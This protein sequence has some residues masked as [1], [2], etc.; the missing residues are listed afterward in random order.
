MLPYLIVLLPAILF[1][2]N[3]FSQ[4]QFIE[5]KGQWD[6]RVKFMSTTG[7]G[8][9][10]LQQNGFTVAQHNSNDIDNVKERRHKEAMGLTLKQGEG[11]KI[12]S[13]AY[14][15]E[16]LNSQ[17]AQIIPDKA[18]P[19]ISNYFIG[20][21]P[22][23]WVSNCKIYQGITYKN[24][25]PGID[26]RYYSDGGEN[27]KYDFIVYPGADVNK[28]V[29]KYT[30]AEKIAI[31]NKELNISTSLGDN[32]ELSPYTYQIDN[33]QRQELKCG[34]D[35]K[36]DV[37]KF[38]VKNY[39]PSKVLIID[40]TEIFFSYSGSTADNWG[41]TA[42]YGPDGSFYGGGIVF[43]DGFPKYTGGYDETFNGNFDIGI[44]KLSPD[45][46]NMIYATYIGGGDAD[47]PHSLIV[48]PQGNLVI[49]GRSSS[50][51]YP[52]W[53]A[54]VPAV[55]G[56]GGGW[57]IIVTKLN[58]TGTALI[59]SMRIGGS[60][61]DG[62]NIQDERVA[63]ANSLK[64]NYGDDARSEVLLDGANNIYLAS[65]TQSPDY[66]KTITP[67][68]FQTKIGGMQDGV[69]L[70]IDPNCDKILFNTFLGG[71]G[72]DAAY[73]LVLDPSNNIYVAGGTGS[74]NFPGISPSGVVSSNNSGGPCDGFIVELNNAGTA[75]I[76][77]TYLGTPAADQIYGIDDDK[78]GNIYVMGTTEGSWP[79]MNAAYSDA[80]AK[81]FI[82]KLKP[83]LSAYIYSTVFGSANSPLPNISPTAFLVD[84]CENVYVSGW[85]GKSNTGFN[86]GNTIGMPTTP[87]AI[88]PRTDVSGSDFYFFVLQKDA[89]SQLYGTFFGQSDPPEGVSNPLTF[90]D[91]VDGGTSRFDRNG[92]IYEAMCANCFR[93]V[94]FSGTAGAWSTRDQATAGGKCNLGM[95][96]IEMDFSGVRAG[97]RAAINGVAYDTTG[98]APVTVNFSDTLKK[99]KLYYWSFG[100][101]TGDTTVAPNDTHIYNN[102]GTYLVRL[103]AVDSTTCN[104]FDTS[105]THIK[106]GDNKVLLDFIP[107]KV[108][109][110]TNLTYSFTNT[111]VPTSGTFNP[112]IFTWDFGDN[113]PLLTASQSPPVTHTY[114]SPGTYL[115][116][117]SINDTTYCNSPADTVKT[118]RLSPQVKAQFET[119]PSGC[120]PYNAV[121]NNTSLGGTSFVWD[122]G[123]GS[124]STDVSPTHLYANAGTY[125][126]KLV[127]FDTSSCN[128]VDS[129]TFT[130]TV[131]PNPIAAFSFAPIPPQENTPTNFTN[132]SIGA[133][134]YLWRFGDGDTS[135]EVNPTHIFLATATYNV[136][137]SAINDY[138]CIADTCMNVQSLIR[139][140]VDLPNAFT[141]GK[142]G[143][144]G[145]IRVV[146]FGIVGMRWTIY[147]RWGQKV[148]EAD[149]I[150]SSW[151][152]TF[153]GKPQPM[154][155]YAYTLEVSFSDG[156]KYRKTGD[157][158]LLR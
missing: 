54:S 26:V 70:K 122:F 78:A 102:I 83:D 35:V 131:S 139:P 58:A 88:K 38:K 151:D 42:T 55:I 28:I 39:D 90:G 73:V 19:T 31:K 75:A 137:L 132:Q 157:I 47:Q 69:V 76:R 106:V 61:N 114:A 2:Q 86:E 17:T 66:D 68:A 146:G 29:M 101:G 140:L 136:C 80:G 129:T 13:H 93:T 149:N 36:G 51:D 6:S 148:F 22:K 5:N 23:K 30:G 57:D 21:D 133:T 98:C 18:L 96:K 154:D 126:I 67:G 97:V 150:K 50:G 92:V 125:N 99:G 77:G 45:G 135:T 142:F 1:A 48:D 94:Q 112:N 84:R 155:V 43:N 16:F 24:V 10:Y 105:Y 116:K 11:T 8:E 82:S 72:D 124:T 41:F 113:S 153:N 3:I 87:D 119:P 156:T 14:R 147:N 33:G 134:H 117:L 63:G 123:D 60:Q 128:K 25:Y 81:Q 115:V 56:P 7:S 53:P 111:S 40:P 4:I 15:V 103:I 62:V 46:K 107:S 71:S 37:V 91:H 109:P 120:V 145:R 138:G 27:L 118:I 9:F 52:T 34:Y 64:R 79:V 65:C 121:F 32:R 127:A 95:L 130:V 100:D 104:I 144:N 158:T 89:A 85:G 108:P 152:G 59:G 49:A 12:R 44:I 141:P 110:C 74:P 20:N 143:V